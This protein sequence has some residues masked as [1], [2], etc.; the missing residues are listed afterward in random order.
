MSPNPIEATTTA[1]LS[2]SISTDIISF[3]FKIKIKEELAEGSSINSQNSKTQ[4]HTQDKKW[5]DLEMKERNHQ[6]Q[7]IMKVK[8]LG[9]KTRSARRIFLFCLAATQT[10]EQA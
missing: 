8:S 10:K 7:K 5:R 4:S 1:L 9:E 6:D 2:S 3:I